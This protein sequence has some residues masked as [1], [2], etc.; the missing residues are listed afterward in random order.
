MNFSVL[1]SNTMFPHPVGCFYRYQAPASKHLKYKIGVLAHRGESVAYFQFNKTFSDYLTYTAGQRFDPPLEFEMVPLDYVK[2]FSDTE[3]AVV[4]FLFVNPSA[5]S[6]LESEY[7]LRSLVSMIN[8]R[9]VNGRVYDLEKFG[10]V[11]MTKANREDIQTMQD[12]KGKIIAASSI[13][14]LGSG[15]MQF[16]RMIEAGMDFMNDPKQL[17]FTSNQNSK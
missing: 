4:D 17:V 7:G 15:Q 11:I 12:L 16:R 13:S 8:R 2:M 5:F 10:G 14:G 3:D 1:R 9:V 6:C